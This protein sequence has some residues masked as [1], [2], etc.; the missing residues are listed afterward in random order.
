MTCSETCLREPLDDQLPRRAAGPEAG[1]DRLL[2][3]CLE[4][5]L[6]LA[7]DLRAR[8]RDLEM[9]LAGADIGDVDFEL[10]LS[11]GLGFVRLGLDRRRRPPQPTLRIRA[12]RCSS[13]A[14]PRVASGR[15][16]LIR[17]HATAALERK[18][19]TQDGIDQEREKGFEPSTPTLATWCSTPE[20]LPHV[21]A[22]SGDAP[23]PNRATSDPPPS[24]TRI[25]IARPPGNA[26][27]LRKSRES[28]L[29]KLLGFP[30]ASGR[31]RG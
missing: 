7:V 12:R 29:E 24:G 2:P 14:F 9:L 10:E 16:G 1:D 8:N 15:D 3:Q 28:A 21:P 30:F 11:L 27:H 18:P 19:P 26:S 4:R 31:A 25:S 20:L 13:Q 23:E 6:V 22:R 5:F 17:H